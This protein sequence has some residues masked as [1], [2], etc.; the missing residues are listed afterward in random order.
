MADRNQPWAQDERRDPHRQ[1]EPWQSRERRAPR[2]FEDD[3][4][5]AF[6]SHARDGWQGGRPTEGSSAQGWQEPRYPGGGFGSEHRGYA[7]AHEAQGAFGQG[8]GHT[9]QHATGYGSHGY[10]G[11]TSGESL[12]TGYG[13]T[14]GHD[15]PRRSGYEGGSGYGLPG[16]YGSNPKHPS[17]TERAGGYGPQGGGYGSQSSYASHGGYGSPQQRWHSEYGSEGEFHSQGYGTHAG[18]GSH[19][20]YGPQGEAHWP[21]SSWAQQRPAQRRGPKGYKRSDERIRE[22]ICE[23]LMLSAFIDSSEVTIEVK[24]GKVI[25]EGTVPERRMK[26]AIEDMAE[27]TAGVNDV[28]NNVRVEQHASGA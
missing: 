17:P 23:R 6:T 27:A 14:A 26:H 22:D 25:M 19:G 10:G 4:R 15:A 1:D 20:G 2:G 18:Y 5:S 7:H 13:S 24:D 28:E 8:G 12:Q 9:A 16:D 3:R 11:Q 21:Q